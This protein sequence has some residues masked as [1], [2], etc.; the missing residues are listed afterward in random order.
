MNRTEWEKTL[1]EFMTYLETDRDLETITIR[2][3]LID[4]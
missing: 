2:N 4:I 3:Y 1:T